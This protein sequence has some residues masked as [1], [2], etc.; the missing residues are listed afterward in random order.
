[1]T[2][3]GAAWVSWIAEN[4][5]RGAPRADLIAGLVTG[6]L[7][8]ER[9][10]SEVD[11]VLTSPIL[12]GARVLVDRSAGVEQAARLRRTLEP[13]GLA[14]RTTLD[15][16]TLYREFWS[17]HRPVVFRGAARD[18]P[19]RSWTPA[20]LRQ[21]FGHVEANVLVDRDPS[22]AW[23]DRSEIT[24]RT[25]VG[26]LMDV[27]EGPAGDGVYADGRTDLFEQP[28]LAPLIDELGLLPGLVGNG[29]P[30]AWIGPAGTV[31]PLHHDQSTGWLVQL[32]G[33]KVV[34]MASPLEPALM[35]TTQG[36]Y[37]HVDP[38]KPAVGELSDVRWHTIELAP[39][40]AL[41][42]VVGWWHHVVALTPSISV[43]MGGFR[44]PNAF[45]W[46]LPGRKA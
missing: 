36:L 9:A 1:M 35:S 30:K 6:G 27:V 37:N 43:S 25:T 28:G 39:G 42:V 22:F 12:R 2:P 18:W 33:R 34:R 24:R 20:G 19:A 44:W 23:R 17:A 13:T 8:G 26:A 11:A 38:R 29:F 7:D 10:A 15:D 14:E 46:Y 16:D 45:P 41:L 3:L 40:D 32:F 31:T 21:R 5:L 4:A